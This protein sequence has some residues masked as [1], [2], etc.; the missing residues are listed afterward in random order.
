MNRFWGEGWERGSF[1]PLLW[2]E[3]DVKKHF[4]C[5]GTLN[6]MTLKILFESTGTKSGKR[7]AVFQLSLSCD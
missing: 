1:P 6:C 3:E 2:R 5:E 7:K 4:V